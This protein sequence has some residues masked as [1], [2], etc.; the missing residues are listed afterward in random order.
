VWTENILYNFLIGTDGYEPESGLTF[1][2]A[3]NLYGTTFYGGGSASA[4]DYGCGTVFK[5]TPSGS[6]TWT[7]STAMRFFNTNG[8]RPSGALVPDTA[9]NLYGTAVQGG[10]ADMGLVFKLTP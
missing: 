8:A 9:G 2:T 10:S 4:C 1:D 6:G 5:L 3:G 7:E